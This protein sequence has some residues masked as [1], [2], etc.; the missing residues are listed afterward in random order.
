MTTTTTTTTN[1]IYLPLWRYLLEFY[2]NSYFHSAI[3]I[4][5]TIN[6]TTNKISNPLETLY[7]K[8]PELFEY[9]PTIR[10]SMFKFFMN[11]EQSMDTIYFPMEILMIS[12]VFGNIILYPNMSATITINE[13]DIIVV[14]INVDFNDMIKKIDQ[15]IKHKNTHVIQNN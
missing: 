2:D 15:L 4:V 11:Y 5:Y 9:Q 3:D 7:F 14:H 12:T 13:H 6:L 8:L 1:N 10:R